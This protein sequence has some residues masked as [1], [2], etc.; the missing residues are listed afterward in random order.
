MSDKQTHLDD[1]EV[2]AIWYIRKLDDVQSS[3]SYAY[4]QAQLGNPAS[5]S[6]TKSVDALQKAEDRLRTALRDAKEFGL[7]KADSESATRKGMER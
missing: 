7:Y 3:V 4:R 5:E 2:A 6:I 1:I